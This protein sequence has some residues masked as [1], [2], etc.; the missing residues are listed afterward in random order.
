MLQSSQCVGVPLNTCYGSPRSRGARVYSV[1]PAASVCGD[2]RPGGAGEPFRGNELV[3]GRGPGGGAARSRGTG[4][5]AQLP[6]MG[7]A[8]GPASSPASLALG[9]QSPPRSAPVTVSVVATDRSWVR[10]R[11]WGDCVRRVPQRRRPADLRGPASADHARRERER[12]EPDGQ[13]AAGRSAG[14]GC[15]AFRGRY[16]APPRPP[17]EARSLRCAGGSLR[18]SVPSLQIGAMRRR[19]RPGRSPGTRCGRSAPPPQRPSSPRA[20]SRDRCGTRAA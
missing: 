16:P 6:A 17:G 15:G 12:V 18:W 14:T 1:Q 8:A 4:S 7:P 11:R 5:S 9:P 3:R 2:V 13:R 20:A 19:W 10:G